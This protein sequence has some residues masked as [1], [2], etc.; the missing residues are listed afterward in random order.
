MKAPRSIKTLTPRLAE[1][2]KIK[3]GGKG[4]EK[5]SRSGKKYR[6]PKKLDHF[7]ISTNERNT[8]GDLIIDEAIM[9]K[10][11][12][13]PRE[14]DVFLLYDDIELNFPHY[15]SYYEGRQC[16]I[17][18]D[19]ETAQVRQEDGTWV[20]KPCLCATRQEPLCKPTGI[21]QVI[22]KEAQTTGG[23][24]VFRTHSWHSV[25]NI[26]SAMRFIQQLTGGIL[27]GIPLK[28][29]LLPKTM[30]HDGGVNTNYVVTLEYA[31]PPQELQRQAVAIAQ[32]RASSMIELK[33]LK[34]LEAARVEQLEAEDVDAEAE[35]I[36]EEFFP[37]NQEG[38]K[39]DHPEVLETQNGV[40]DTQT[41][42]IVEEVPHE[43]E[44][45][46]EPVEV[47]AEAAEAAPNSPAC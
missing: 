4:E 8:R 32:T 9:K 22:L 16:K 28:L 6:M 44:S 45:E 24:Y 31:G 38:Y 18:C 7:I 5:V 10:L 12:P 34:A 17:R 47:E 14:L 36:V 26:V 33:K 42:E 13:E 40:I 1:V 20:E 30:E 25:N 35:D 29:K 27:A 19:G 21:L 11:G 37:E 3:I 43:A 41:G 23:V 39:E 2:G 46:V 15:F